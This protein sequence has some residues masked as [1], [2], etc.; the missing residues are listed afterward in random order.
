[1]F[2]MESPQH[3]RADFSRFNNFFN[4]TMTYRL[5]SD[6]S[7]PYGWVL[8]KPSN[9]SYLEQV[10][11]WD[12]DFD[13]AQFATTL[14]LK[15]AK[16]RALAHRPKGI[17]WIV[18]NCNSNSDRERYVNELRNYVEVDIFGSCG[19]QLC[20]ANGSTP[21]TCTNIEQNYMFYLSFENSFCDHYVTE[22]LWFWLSG[23]IVPVVMGQAN[24][25]AITPPHSIIDTANFP[26]PAQ[27]AGTNCIK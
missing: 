1:M 22:K 12:H 23:D 7:I 13:Y 6:I 26:E 15:P 14:H 2:F 19:N 25:T 4:W 18:S 16:F 10:R 17:A 21:Q 20:F 5:D 9:K 24:Y 27:L 3:W 11:H 8:P